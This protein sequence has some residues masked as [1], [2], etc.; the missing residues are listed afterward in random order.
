MVTPLIKANPDR[1]KTNFNISKEKGNIVTFN[2][3]NLKTPF[4]FKLEFPNYPKYDQCIL[5]ELNTEYKTFFNSN[6]FF[7]RDRILQNQLGVAIDIL[8]PHMTENREKMSQFFLDNMPFFEKIVSQA[9]V[10]PIDRM[11]AFAGHN[12]QIL[13]MNDV[14]R[15]AIE[16][17]LMQGVQAVK[18]I[19]SNVVGPLDSGNVY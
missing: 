3:K 13:N 4:C 1:Y 7:Q 17:F 14:N 6:E 8:N 5:I 15:V 19:Y 9:M 12:E 18:V 2:H 10:Q 16:E 11:F